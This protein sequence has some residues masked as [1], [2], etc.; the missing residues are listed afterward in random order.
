MITQVRLPGPLKRFAGGDSSVA[1]EAETVREA[2]HALVQKCEGIGERLHDE[3]GEVRKAFHIFLND[4]SVRSLGGLDT[5][6]KEGDQVSILVA[7]SG[8]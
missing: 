5:V 1:V 8:G 6:I 7:F 2:L 3:H 4:E